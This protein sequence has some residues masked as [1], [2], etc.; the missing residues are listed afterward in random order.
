MAE[1]L[2]VILAGRVIGQ[3]ER[4]R[5][6]VMRFTYDDDAMEAGST[7]LSLSMPL[8]RKS[9]TGDVVDRFVHALVPEA[10][11]ALAAIERQHPGVDRRDDLSLLAVIGKDCPGAVQ[12]S[13]PG[14][15]ESTVARTGHLELQSPSDI[16]M[17][18]AELRTNE[19]A[20][21]T[22][23]GEHWSLG[24]TQA[25]FALRRIDG[26][27]FEAHGSQP[28]SHI[29][30]PGIHKLF[31]QS[32]VEHVTMRGAARC[33]LDV[34]GTEHVEFKTESAIVIE[35]F[36]RRPCGETLVRLHQ[37]DMCQA[38]GLSQKYEDH[39]GPSARDI[40]RMMRAITPGRVEAEANV[41]RF[42]DGVIFNTVLA[43]PDGH[44]R[45]YAVL[46][47][48]ERVSLAPLYDVATGIVYA[49]STPEGRG[50]SP[51]N[52]KV[53]MS[54]GGE[55][56][57]DRIGRDEWSRF[58]DENG[59]DAESLLERARTIAA[60]APQA[61]LGALDEVAAQADDWSGEITELRQRMVSGLDVR[62]ARAE[63]LLGPR[64]SGRSRAHHPA[65]S[66]APQPRDGRGQFARKERQQGVGGKS[67]AGQ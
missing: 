54:I 2:S 18:L 32:L 61:I 17:R 4:T 27:W 13:L 19:D 45:N 11:S 55:F 6:N 50:G 48:G 9:Y 35:R 28:T 62:A 25:K 42:V 65:A 44:A 53:S 36:D 7:P 24:G 20:S 67:G 47:D 60:T 22:M 33:G 46:L 10:N 29:V 41:E 56:W 16:E 63:K 3:V 37:E 49:T 59:L 5:N 43:C 66:V 38:L 57:A 39:Q 21:W 52:Q 31:A 15:V 23:P 40:I 34:A 8:V 51:E 58:A 26:L 12:F 30:K 1:P 14:E 64:S